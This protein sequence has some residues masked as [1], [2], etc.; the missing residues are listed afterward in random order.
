MPKAS[1]HKK[2]TKKKAA[3]KKARPTTRAGREQRAKAN[4]R[5][6]A[7]RDGAIAER[8]APVRLEAKI[9]KATEQ[10]LGIQRNPNNKIV[11]AEDRLPLVIEMASRGVRECDIALAL[12][13]SVPTWSRIK[14]EQPEFEHALTAGRGIEHDK[15]R[16]VMYDKCIK[17]DR[18]ACTFLLQTQFGYREGGTDVEVINNNIKITL[19]AAMDRNTYMRVIEGTASTVSEGDNE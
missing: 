14:K 4:A 2:A 12:G 17:G 6:R 15:I 3:K 7:K 19:P 11:L 1:G 10:A 9:K 13:V 16:G 5:K 18:R 8:L